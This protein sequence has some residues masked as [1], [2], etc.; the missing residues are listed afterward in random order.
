MLDRHV[1]RPAHLHFMVSSHRIPKVDEVQSNMS[2][3]I[4]KGYKSVVTQIFDSDSGYLGND[5]VFAVKDG[6]TV[7]FTPRKDDP[8]ADWE[9]EYN[10]SL[11]SES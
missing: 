1:Y 5:S 10:M 6:L 3:V 7:T 4:A 8:Q 2:Q 9:L 11:A